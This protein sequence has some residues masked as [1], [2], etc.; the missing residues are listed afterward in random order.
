[1]N[2]KLGDLLG[3]SEDVPPLFLTQYIRHAGAIL[4]GMTKTPGRPPERFR[5]PILGA[6]SAERNASND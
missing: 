1:V 5:L 4:S 6:T 2:R 3:E